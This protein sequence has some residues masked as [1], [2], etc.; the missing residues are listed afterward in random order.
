[1]D[2]T[3]TDFKSEDFAVLNDF[4]KI[5]EK[6]LLGSLCLCVRMKQLGFHRADIWEI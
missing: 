5:C 4:R 2:K 6:R 3:H 1:M